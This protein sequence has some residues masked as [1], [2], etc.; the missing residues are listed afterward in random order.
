MGEVADMDRKE[1]GVATEVGRTEGL[2][3]MV[4]GGDPGALFGPFE[5]MVQEVNVGGMSEEADIQE[6]GGSPCQGLA[7][8]GCSIAGCCYF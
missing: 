7:S 3:A 4:G 1:G 2:D 8:C 6:V 5:V